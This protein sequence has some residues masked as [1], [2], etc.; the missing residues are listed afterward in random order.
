MLSILL[1]WRLGNFFEFL[2]RDVLLVFKFW[3]GQRPA[4]ECCNTKTWFEFKNGMEKEKGI[5][6]LIW[7]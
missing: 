6:E 3:T 5:N 7:Y 2:K 4:F 1:L